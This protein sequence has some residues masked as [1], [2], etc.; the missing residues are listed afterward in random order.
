MSA[1]REWLAVT[2]GCRADGAVGGIW[3]KLR[4]IVGFDVSPMLPVTVHPAPATAG[5][6]EAAASA[7]PA[8]MTHLPQRMENRSRTPSICSKEAPAQLRIL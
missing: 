8:Q 4:I 2:V 1:I 7:S 5:K 6:A 3:L